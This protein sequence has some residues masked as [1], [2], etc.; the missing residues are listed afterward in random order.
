MIPSYVIEE[1]KQH[2]NI[3]QYVSQY[4]QLEDRNGLFYSLCCF[5]NEDTPSL[6][7]FESTQLYFCFACG[8]K[9]DIIS[10]IQ[11]Y[12]KLNFQQ[13]VEHLIKYLNYDI[14]DIKEEFG[15]IKILKQY[16]VKKYKEKIT[17]TILPNS[18]LNKYKDKP[19]QQW[20]DEGI[21]LETMKKFGVLYDD[22]TNR[23]VFPIY[24]NNGNLISIKGRTL[25]EDYK[26][27]GLTKYIYYHSLGSSD[28]LY[29][30]CMNKN[31]I[32]K[33]NEV[34]IVEGE[35]SVW[36]F[37]DNNIYNVVA[38]SSCR[39]N[40]YQMISLI[41]LKC[42][43]VMALDKDKNS[44]FIKEQCELLKRFTNVYMIY[45]T[46]NILDEKDSPIDKGVETWKQLYKQRTKLM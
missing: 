13:A 39:I 22:K 4:L 17:H 46:H 25:Y 37:H 36:K 19:I 9:G 28:F 40:E 26:T 44:S 38:L 32:K 21:S 8:A 24:D 35:K 20:I 5:H 29:G 14:K 12:H 10:F 11:K 43:V 2:S 6:V 23:A 30:L 16:N 18:I 42:D 7:F 31:A 15:I 33:Y 34:I 1:I 27:L 45:D 3:V 41:E